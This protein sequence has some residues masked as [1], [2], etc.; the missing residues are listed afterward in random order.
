M[1]QTFTNKGAYTKNEECFHKIMLFG[2]TFSATNKL[3]AL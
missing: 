2:T 3:H 1:H